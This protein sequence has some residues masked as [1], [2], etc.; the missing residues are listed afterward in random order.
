MAHNFGTKTDFQVSTSD[1]FWSGLSAA[2]QTNVAANAAFLLGQVETA[3]GTTT[4]WF[5]TDTSKFGT[6]HRQ[7]IILDQAD[8][9][10]AFNNG[11]GN[12]IHLDAQSNNATATGGPIISMLWI[13]EWSEV[14]MSLTSNWNA[15]DSS[16]EALSQLCSILLFQLG[17]YDYYSSGSWVEQWLNG[18]QAW[19]SN[20]KT[21][22]ASPNSARS[23]WVTQTFTG[24]TTSAGDQIHGDGD[25]VSFGCGLAFL[26]Y[27]T[28]QLGFTLNEIIPDYNS[29]LAAAYNKLTGDPGN[30]FPFFLAL[31]ESVYPSGSTATIPGP[32]PDNPFPMAI[33]AFWNVKSIFGKDEA[34]D[35]INTQGGL[36]SG[37]FWI[38]VEGFSKQSFN[39]LDVTVGSFSGDFFNLPGVTIS[40]N[41]RGVQF[42]SG[43]N[44]KTP[45]RIGIP[46]DITLS[47]PILSQFPGTGSTQLSLSVSLVSGGNQV[48]GSSASTL[49]E[50][51]AGA[52][53]YFM[54]IDPNQG[55]LA[56]LSQDLRVFTGT[57]ALNSV[58]ITGGP[59]LT[60]SV[61]GAFSYIQ[62]LLTYLNA[63]FNNPAGTDPFT[64]IFPDQTNA[65]QGD[66]SVTPF[67][68]DFSGGVFN[69][70]IDNNYNFAVARVRLRGS[71][72]VSG[73]AEN[74]RV[75]FRLFC[76]Q[77]NDTDYDINSTYKS[78]PDTGGGPGTPLVGSGNTTIPFFAT[79]NLSSQTDYNSGGPNIQTL[80]IP[81]HRDSLWAYYGCFLNLYDSANTI[82]GAQVQTLLTGAHHCLVAQIAFDEAPIPQGSSPLSWDQ[83]AQRNL[84]VTLSDNPG[85]AST[86]RIPQTFD[87]RPSVGVVPPSGG[88]SSPPDELMIEW[89]SVPSGSV[90]SIYWPQALAADVINLANQ[91]YSSNPIT[92]IDS[93]TLRL[94]IT[95]GVSY[96][97]IPMGAG[98]NFAGLFT[99]DLPAGK[100][101]SGQ[102]FDVFVRRISYSSFTP[103][104]PIQ[105]PP[106]T[107]AMP[108]T[109]GTA[110]HHHHHRKGAPPAKAK[111]EG[112]APKH[113]AIPPLAAPSGSFSW[114]YAVGGFRVRIPVTTSDKILPSEENTLAIMKW[115]LLEMAPSNRWYPVLERYISYLS[116]RVDGLGGNSGGIL[117][118]PVGVL[119]RKPLPSEHVYTGKVCEIHF[120]C[121]GCFDGFV[122]ESCK[123]SHAFKTRE[124]G[125]EEIV[126]RACKERLM[127]TVV[128]EPGHEHRICKLT[129]SC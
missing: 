81:D 25:A 74:V 16:G 75:F 66:S 53:P 92:A 94:K 80:E 10:G 43:V 23:D 120:D 41:P 11:Y 17:H 103:P 3:F 8:N 29:N 106:R 83:L 32:V 40:P 91:F 22:V 90:A 62:N 31:I 76:T 95:S 67:T 46:Y 82:N 121:F 113:G 47:E 110:S 125:I 86:H 100:V 101:S 124:R 14:L 38:M 15:G 34:N 2:Q 68:V 5:G 107:H 4:G 119:P 18:G 64:T 9:S 59:S 114:G 69:F 7:Q 56:Y 105:S 117:P 98:E 36:V 30:P 6:A 79:G 50:L 89:G 60:D 48:S 93:H 112:E 71:S 33:T 128:V 127:L 77:S 118:S 21:F 61:A 96:V 72:G 52:D 57:P 85:P 45:Q 20:N 111:A 99:I 70:K 42:Q 129:I 116:G 126:L 63:N 28:V 97:P 37:A 87:C 24:L 65:N 35:I 44:D 27:L 51:L 115:R 55:N 1:S 108:S 109:V 39:A 102:T 73:E 123:D 12:P 58:P 54:N 49:F 84:Q 13:A 104:P 122:L 78:N 26:Y 88:Q 19:S